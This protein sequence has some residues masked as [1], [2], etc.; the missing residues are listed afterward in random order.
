[1]RKTFLRIVTLAVTLSVLFAVTAV[2]A[3]AALNDDLEI[4]MQIYGIEGEAKDSN[5]QQWIEL[6]YLKFASTQSV[7]TGSP[8]A[9]GRG[10]FEPVVFKHV[11]DK[12]SPK[13]QEACMKGRKIDS[14]VIECCRSIAGKQEV[15]YKVQLEGIKIVRAEVETVELEEGGTQLVETVNLLVNKMV[16]TKF[17][18]GLNNAPSGDSAASFDLS[19]RASMF[20]SNVSIVLTAAC[21]VIF[22]LLVVIVI[23]VVSQKKKAVAANVPANDKQNS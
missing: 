15:V 5:H 19:Q 22:V 14:A 8:E 6:D 17:S 3:S 12:A 16:W 4:Y 21:A 9:A 18:F 23:L 2:P 10:I 11:V 13:L 1:M 7:Q 20:D